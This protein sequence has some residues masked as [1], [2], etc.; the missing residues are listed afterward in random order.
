MSIAGE[1][2]VLIIGAGPSGAAAG[3]VLC[4]AGFDVCVVDAATFPRDKVCGDAVS[5]QGIRLLRTLGAA[6]AM[7]QLP[8]ARVA[9]A[10]AVFPNGVRIER[11]YSE[12]GYTMPRLHLDDCLRRCLEDSGASVI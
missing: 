5:N 7:S 6:D 8:H 1:S 11:T 12:A 3:I 2:D 4:R 10:A 9:R